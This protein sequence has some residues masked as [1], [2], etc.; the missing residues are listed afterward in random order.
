MALLKE[1]TVSLGMSIDKNGLWVKPG[2]SLKVELSEQDQDPANRRAVVQRVF[3]ILEEDLNEEI[4][5][6]LSE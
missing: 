4:G 5:R 1:I 3:E 2:M 6:L